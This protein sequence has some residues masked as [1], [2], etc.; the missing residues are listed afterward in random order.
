VGIAT[1]SVAG[2][3][4]YTSEDVRLQAVTAAA[5][6]FGP[7]TLKGESGRLLPR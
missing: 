1:V 4:A 5:T 3:E 7:G 2:F 6:G